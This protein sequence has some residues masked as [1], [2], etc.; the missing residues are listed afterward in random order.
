MVSFRK[1]QA[2]QS[3]KND[4]QDVVR[5]AIEDEKPVKEMIL[6]LKDA[7]TKT[8]A[9]QEHDAVVMVRLQKECTNF[10][11]TVQMTIL[12]RTNF[13]SRGRKFL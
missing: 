8:S 12:S 6:E 7:V 11:S 2:A 5:E 3:S 13:L 9:I 10:V 1:Q 4:F